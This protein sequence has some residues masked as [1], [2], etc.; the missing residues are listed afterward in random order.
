MDH[1]SFVRSRQR[2]GRL[3][4]NVD[5][6]FEPYRPLLDFLTQGLSVNELGGDELMSLDLPDVVNRN[7]VGMIQARGSLRFLFKPAQPLRVLS[8]PDGQEFECD[9]PAE[10]RVF[11]Q[12]YFAHSTGADSREY[13]VKPDCGSSRQVRRVLH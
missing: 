2:I 1:S 13:L 5:R 8:K 11:G 12:I 9:L 10:S 3:Q 6:L 4:G 7:D